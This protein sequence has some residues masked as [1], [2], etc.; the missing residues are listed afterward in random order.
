MKTLPAWP[1]D[2]TERDGAGINAGRRFGARR[3]YTR[4][5]GSIR[6][7]AHQGI[8]FLGDGPGSPVYAADSG[9]VKRA[10]SST[11]GGITVW[12]DS[13][14]GYQTRYLHLQSYAVKNGQRVEAGERIATLGRTAIQRSPAML[15][16]ELR[17]P[18]GVPVDPLPALRASD[19]G[20]ALIT[21]LLTVA[22]AAAMV[23][24]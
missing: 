15:H 12:L 24:V 4:A 23:L 13:D 9:T 7:G 21:L 20:G 10:Y 1:V 17:T 18:A 19:A 14:D 5:D 11:S 2:N 22:A 16:F 8:D 3:H 6:D